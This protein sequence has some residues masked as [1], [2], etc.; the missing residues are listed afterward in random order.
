MIYG[1]RFAMVAFV[2]L[3]YFAIG[4]YLTV[5]PTNPLFMAYQNVVVYL[6]RGAKHHWNSRC[7]H[8]DT[9]IKSSPVL[10]VAATSNCP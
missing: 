9:D 2:S 6:S 3:C 1:E 8:I 7:K 4:N 10:P 5:L